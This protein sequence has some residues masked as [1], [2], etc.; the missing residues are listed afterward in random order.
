MVVPDLLETTNSVRRRS[1]F[2]SMAA[3]AAGWVLSRTSISGKPGPLPNVRR[4]TSG[5]RLDPPMPSRTTCRKLS[6]LISAAKDAIEANRPAMAR[7]S[8]SQP[9]RLVISGTGPA[10]QSVGS[11]SQRRA[12]KR[13]TLQRSRRDSTAFPKLPIS[14]VSDASSIS[15][16][17]NPLA[18]SFRCGRTGWHPGPRR[19]RRPE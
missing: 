13:S 14:N 3:T 12:R 11:F 17:M 8:A 18:F 15:G 7:G 1:I 19:R 2:F 10:A 6:A 16:M 5:P 9:S 4:K